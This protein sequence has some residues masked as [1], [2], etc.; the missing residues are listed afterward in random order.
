MNDK[1]VKTLIAVTIIV[2]LAVGVYVIAG[3]SASTDMEAVR[4][5]SLI[6][7]ANMIA[8]PQEMEGRVLLDIRTPQEFASGHLPQA[9][10]IDFYAPDFQATLNELDRNA[11]YT[12]YCRSGSR[13]SQ[14]LRLMQAMGFTDVTE[15]GGGV[16]AWQATGG[17]LCREC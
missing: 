13:T 12:I 2:G 11:P 14:A 17:G 6:T 9:Q 7:N 1:Q 3:K 16:L 15:L 10:N 4:S 5:T 8:M